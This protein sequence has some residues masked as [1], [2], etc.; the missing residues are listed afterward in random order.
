MSPVSITLVR[1]WWSHGRLDRSAGPRRVHIVDE[2]GAART[3]VLRWAPS[4]GVVP[5]VGRVVVVRHVAFEDLGVIADVVGERGM[6]VH[7][8]EAGMDPVDVQEVLGAD[9]LVV[10][11][12]PIGVGDVGRYPF[13]ADEMDAI[14]ARLESGGATF[15]VCLGAQLMAAVLGARVAPNGHHEIGWSPLGLTAAG[16]DSVLAPLGGVP[17]LHW[18]GD[19]FEIPRCATSRRGRGSPTRPSTWGP[20]C[21]G[22]T[23]HLEAR[24]ERIESWL[25]GHAVEL[26]A[27]GVDPRD[28][29]AQARGVGSRLPEV[30]RA[31]VHAWLDGAL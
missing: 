12:G 24:P 29:R 4:M 27:A 28:L 16:E 2:G 7:V 15:G 11:G 26:A 6:D 19:Q 22:W 9:L 3:R 20:G 25:V 17:V 14:G 10:L 31:V 21:W 30:A 5:M 18:H 8:L 1:R 23:P 13:L